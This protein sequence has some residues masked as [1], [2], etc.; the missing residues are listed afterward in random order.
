MEDAGFVVVSTTVE[1]ESAGEKMAAAIVEARLAA[2]VQVTNVSSTYRWKGAVEN[3]KEFLLLAKTR[4][5]LAGK[6]VD[7][8]RSRHSYELPEITVMPIC[9]G[10][11][12]YLD[13]I[14]EETGEGE[15]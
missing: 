4:A 13:W 9:G 10:L 3:A 1:D 11:K 2:C 5:C 14:V 8:V 7:F 15:S 12:G 6:L